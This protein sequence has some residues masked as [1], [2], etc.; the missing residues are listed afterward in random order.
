MGLRGKGGGGNRQA[1][2]GLL[3]KQD[4]PEDAEG[5]RGGKAEDHKPERYKLTAMHRRFQRAHLLQPHLGARRII[6]RQ[7]CL[8]HKR[9]T[10]SSNSSI[11]SPAEHRQTAAATQTLVTIDKVVYHRSPIMPTHSTCV[12]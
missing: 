1:G 8:G 5:R 3:G 11:V 9:Q 7:H 4:A 2:P 6:L 10:F 12:W